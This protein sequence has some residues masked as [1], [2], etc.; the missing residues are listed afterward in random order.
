MK[1]IFLALA[2]VLIANLHT[3]AQVKVT[4]LLCENKTNPVG[5][6]LRNPA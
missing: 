6:A 3:V 4:N 2:V 1:K 5:L